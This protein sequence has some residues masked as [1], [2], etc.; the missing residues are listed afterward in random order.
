MSDKQKTEQLLQDC[1][2]RIFSP[3]EIVSENIYPAET[4]GTKGYKADYDLADN[5]MDGVYL[6]IW[7]DNFIYSEKKTIYYG[8]VF[9]RAK[10]T[11]KDIY[12][13]HKDKH[14]EDFREITSSKKYTTGSRYFHIKEEISKTFMLEE[15]YFEKY[16]GGSKFIGRF[17]LVDKY[18]YKNTVQTITQFLTSEMFYIKKYI[19]TGSTKKDDDF[20]ER[21]RELQDVP[22][23]AL[24]K[25]AQTKTK[26][27]LRETKTLAYVRNPAVVVLAKR[28][29][30]GICQD[31]LK[32]APFKTK[33]GEPYLEV[34]HKRPLSEG[35]LDTV[36]NATALCPNCHRKRH[37]G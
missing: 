16:I 19:P 31:C 20:G 25:Q 35:G 10:D 36:K 5:G 1:L 11:F 30:K 15:T 13:K 18:S 7:I 12:T 27:E 22:T 3:K 2:E 34:H 6:T 8:F 33:D 17:M 21:V 24:I 29:A 32:P 14:S 9:D 28:Y 37:F 23:S 4:S 26:P